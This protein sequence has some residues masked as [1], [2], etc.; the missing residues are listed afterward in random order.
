MVNTTMNEDGAAN[1][2]FGCAWET[3]HGTDSL[4]QYVGNRGTYT[5][6][7]TSATDYVVEWQDG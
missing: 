2:T 1:T 4:E 3:V 7:F 6:Y 5:G